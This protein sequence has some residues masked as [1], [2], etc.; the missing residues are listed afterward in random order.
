ML[1]TESPDGTLTNYARSEMFVEIISIA[2]VS[3]IGA[4]CFKV[5]L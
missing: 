1:Q 2:K 5:L 3:S 4:S